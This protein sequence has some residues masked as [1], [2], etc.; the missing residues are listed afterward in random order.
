MHPKHYLALA[1]VLSPI[2]P[3]STAFATSVSIALG[4]NCV[5][6][7]YSN[8]TPGS[9]SASNAA[10]CTGSFSDGVASASSSGSIEAPFAVQLSATAAG[11]ATDGAI[12]VEAAATAN[13]DT[14]VD[15]SSS[16]AAQS[17]NYTYNIGFDL[18]TNA[19]LNGVSANESVLGLN[20][21]A[22]I[23]AVFNNSQGASVIINS[24]GIILNNAKLFTDVPPVGLFFTP[25][26]LLLSSL[27]P[28]MT[29]AVILS[30]LGAAPDGDFSLH[31]SY[32][33]SAQSDTFEG[34]DSTSLTFA[35]PLAFEVLDPNGNIVQGLTVTTDD[36]TSIPTVGAATAVPEPAALPLFATGL[37]AMAL[38]SWRRKRKNA[39]AIAAV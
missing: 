11:G 29:T 38:F 25:L 4:G 33:V 35:D 34:V 3:S 23:G 18:H 14:N 26:G 39:P 19:L 1:M 17:G 21:T 30:F 20:S 5:S 12:R 15:F 9:T 2:A 32:S 7:A 22:Q 16:N 37:G 6:N 10:A 28:T 8:V 24:T 27:D 13:V 36:G 31:A